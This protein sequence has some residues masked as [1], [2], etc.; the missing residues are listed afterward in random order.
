[1]DTPD[2]VTLVDALDPDVIRERLDELHRQESA[3]RAL[4]RAALARR[5]GVARRPAGTPPQGQ[6]VRR[7]S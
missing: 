2:P 7:G 5:R 6:E 4:L 3:L 1:M